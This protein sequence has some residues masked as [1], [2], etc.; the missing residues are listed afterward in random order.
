MLSN[1][2]LYLR[3]YVLLSSL[4][5]G[6]RSYL[7]SKSVQRYLK[8]S[9]MN[10]LI[11]KLL[12]LIYLL[13]RSVNSSYKFSP[14]MIDSSKEP[15]S[16]KVKLRI[17]GAALFCMCSFLHAFIIFVITNIAHSRSCQFDRMNSGLPCNTLSEDFLN[18]NLSARIHDNRCEKYFPVGYSQA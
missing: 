14:S 13:K 10:L 6:T 17:E 18:W 4:L 7:E 9:Y 15:R 2:R 16:I 12:S 11:D 5:S 3:K 8:F 1:G